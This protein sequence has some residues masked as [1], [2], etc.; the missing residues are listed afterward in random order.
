MIFL[1]RIVRTE[2]NTDLQK[3]EVIKI[4]VNTLMRL[5]IC[6]KKDVVLTIAILLALLS[7][8]FVHPDKQ[9]INY[10]DYRTLILLFCLMS[11]MAGLRKIKLFDRVAA[12]LVSR[13]TNEG[14]LIIL[15]VVVVFFTSMII[16]NDVALLTFVPFT[17]SVLNILHPNVK[18]RWMITLIVMETIAANLGSMLTPVGNPQ[19]LYLYNV[20]G[21]SMGGFLLIMLP[22]SVLSLVMLIIWI[23]IRCNSKSTNIDRNIKLG[24][25]R[26]T[27]SEIAYNSRDKRIIGM[28]SFLFILCLMTVVKIIPFYI[29]FVILLVCILIFDRDTLKNVDYSLI[30][31]FTGFFIFI[32]NI[33]RIPLFKD[34]LQG[35]ISGKEMITAVLCS[36]IMSNVPAALLLTGFTDNIRMLIIG[37][38]LGGLGTLIASMASLISFKFI[39]REDKNVNGTYIATFTVANVVFLICLLVL[40]QIIKLL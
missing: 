31:T 24:D 10:I 22:Y 30:F 11:V 8:L 15:L 37:T 38:N 23:I 27:N 1:Y 35:F 26:N 19:N 16:T 12:T 9:Y 28:Y 20:S 29:T 32:G 3:N 13:C 33:G 4:M 39:Q 25:I 6:L 36:Q 17:I 14:Q 21:M 18:N 2:K 5:K 40:Y 34:F 7:S